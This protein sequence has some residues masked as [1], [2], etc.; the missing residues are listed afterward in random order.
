MESFFFHPKVVH[1]PI[2]LALLMPLVAA[3]V[4]VGWL[5]RWW[6]ARTWVIA[7]ALQGA[8]VASGVVA[9]QSGERD[10]ELVESI[11]PEPA[12]EAHEEAAAQ[13]VWA[14]GVVA[15]AMVGALALANHPAGRVAA[16]VGVLGTL[17]V[18]ALGYRTG[19][20]GG[21]LVYKHGAASAFT[22]AG[23][24]G[25]GLGGARAGNDEQEERD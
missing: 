4:W 16:A 19:Q 3:G 2:A 21:A 20:A 24:T 7:L 1:I 11:V 13:F 23:G 6:P 8:L 15:L 25:A 17:V 22:A 12:L 18:L 14:G 10:E 5:R 9:M